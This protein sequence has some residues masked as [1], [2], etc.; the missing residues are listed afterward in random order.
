MRNRTGGTPQAGAP[1]GAWA[2]L[3]H[4]SHALD[5][6]PLG[7][8]QHTKDDVFPTSW[9]RNW[10]SQDWFMVTYFVI[11]LAALCMG[12]GANRSAC[13]VRVAAD[14]GALLFV[15]ALVRGS[16]LRPASGGTALLYRT[17]LIGALLSSFFQLREILPAVAPWSVDGR[18]YAFDLQGLR[19]RAERLHGPVRD[20]MRRPNGSPSS[21]FSTFSSFASTS[22]RW[23]TGIVTRGS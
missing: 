6:D 4:A 8:R 19:L 7:V 2:L 21:T 12:R 11:L 14:L 17:A 20:A 18:I 3:S 5:A 10:A 9:V 22:C 15:L 23:C 16:V 13:I 1:P